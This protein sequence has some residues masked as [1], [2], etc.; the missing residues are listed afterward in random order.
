MTAL[1]DIYKKSLMDGALPAYD[2]N[3][4]KVGIVHIG[5]GGFHRAHQALYLEKYLRAHP[6]DLNWG[7]LGIGLM[8]NDTAF[9]AQ[10]NQQQGLYTLQLVDQTQRTYYPIGVIKSTLSGSDVPAGA[11]AAM[12]DPAVKIIS[13]TITEGGYLYDFETDQFMADHPLVR[14]DLAPQNTPKCIHGFLA[15]ALRQRMVDGAGPVT[16]L[17][18]DNVPGNGQVLQRALTAFIAL[19]GDAALLAWLDT[20]VSFPNSMVDRITPMPTAAL[21]QQVKA[22]LGVDDLCPV[23]GE[24]FG[25][26]V[27]EDHFIA[28]RPALETV[29][30]EFTDAVEDY[31]KLKLRILNGT[32]ILIALIGYVDGLTYIHEC[33][34]DPLILQRARELMDL[35]AHPAIEG[36]SDAAINDYKH[37]IVQRFSNPVTLDSVERVASDGFNKLKNYLMPI[38]RDGMSRGRISPLI[39]LA[40]ACYARHL[41]GINDR[42]QAIRVNEPRLTMAERQTYSDDVEAILRLESFFGQDESASVKTFIAQTQALYEVIKSHGVRD[43]L[44]SAVNAS[45]EE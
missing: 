31:E 33:M 26:W 17:S 3:V 23:L 10:L 8:P 38:L 5:V 6:D 42:G 13:M 14:H 19:T 21:Q 12:A 40:F 15:R 39:S 32:H 30:V 44:T 41:K 36:F 27:V 29:G 18:C 43:A 35:D 20:H 45:S 25:Q 34:E 9:L 2:R 16:L 7:I 1:L 11:V 24:P 28:G 22:D 37:L 4:L